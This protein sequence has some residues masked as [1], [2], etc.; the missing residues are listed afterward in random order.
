ML[1]ATLLP[2]VTVLGIFGALA[3]EVARRS[4][5][6]ELGKRLATAAAGAAL[7]VLPEQITAIAAGDE[8]TLTYGNLRRRLDQAK[9]QFRVRR[10]MLVARDL[11]GRGDTDERVALGATAHELGADLVEIER[12][13]AGR[14]SSSPLF[15]GRDG[16]PYK[17]GYA[18]IGAPEAVGFVVVEG[19][20]GYFAALAA[21]R[22]WLIV[23]GFIG[24]SLI[25]ASAMIIARRITG[26][27]ERLA[28]AAERIGRGELKA[29]VPV[30]TNDELGVLATRLD[31]MRAALQARDE[32]LQMML[33]GIAHEVRNPLGGLAL[34]AGL[35]RE[36]LASRPDALAQVAR[37]EREVQCLQSVVSD[38]L[39]YARRPPPERAPIPVR[40]LLE[41]VVELCRV[42]NAGPSVIIEASPD[43]SASGDRGQLRRAL[44]NLVRNAITAAGAGGRVVVA[45]R[46]DGDA[47]VV[48][49]VRDS[50][51]G[52][53][54]EMREKIFA[55][56]FTTREKGTGLG[57]AFVRDIVRDHGGEVTLER[58]PEGGAVFRFSV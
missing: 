17:R 8:Q 48:W 29:T 12:A 13:A 41:E 42:S 40:V 30:E 32:R 5:E 28:R 26:P 44:I 56:F 47:R 3:H 20:A 1:L 50:G 22:R 23:G 54:Q 11:A 19:D 37:I 16:L 14:P 52:V 57:L 9:Q 49:E 25:S 45:A 10:V 39:E 43:L 33:A 24:V 55:P 46:P 58:A 34:Y 27:L 2:A 53:P 4:L 35:L 7:L 15:A 6:D 18:R 38:F 31:Q 36:D 51:A 21:F